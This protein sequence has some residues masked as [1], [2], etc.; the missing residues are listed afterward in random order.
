MARCAGYSALV[1]SGDMVLGLG[2]G[3][4]ALKI[5]ARNVSYFVANAILQILHRESLFGVTGWA[6]CWL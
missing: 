6:V 1:G 2:F 3:L 5:M 4:P